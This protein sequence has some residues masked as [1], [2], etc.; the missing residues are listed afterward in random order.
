[1]VKIIDPEEMEGYSPL[2]HNAVVN[3]QMVGKNIGSSKMNAALGRM[4]PGGLT[5]MH[6]HDNSE[7]FHYV[8]KGEVTITSPDGNFKLAEGRGC[9]SAA[10]ELHGM[11][12]ETS[13]DSIYL[14]FTAPTIV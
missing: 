14:V 13:Q 12:N 10:G 3:K 5:E 1:M 9:W 4:A 8:L 11:L 6:S 7:Q 2:G